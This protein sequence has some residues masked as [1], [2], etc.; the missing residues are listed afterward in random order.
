LCTSTWVAGKPDAGR[1]VHGFRH[2][3]D[4]LFQRFV[5][6]GDRAGYFMQPSVGVAKNVQKRHLWTIYLQ[7]E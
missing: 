2:V 6:N 1:R 3:G 7:I 5:E 4:E